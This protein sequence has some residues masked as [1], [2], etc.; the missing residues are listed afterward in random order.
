MYEGCRRGIQITHP[1]VGAVQRAALTQEIRE[2]HPSV[3]DGFQPSRNPP[4]SGAPRPT[5]PG[6]ISQR[7]RR[8]QAPALRRHEDHRPR[9]PLGGGCHE[10]TGGVPSVGSAALPCLPGHSLSHRRLAPLTAPS[11]REPGKDRPL[12]RVTADHGKDRKYLSKFTE[13]RCFTGDIC[14]N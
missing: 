5:V 2:T 8:G 11:G 3:G 7:G 6:R 12:Q 9:P 10:V 13:N 1:S 14:Y 4:V